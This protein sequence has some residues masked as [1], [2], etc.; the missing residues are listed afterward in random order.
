MRQRIKMLQLV[1]KMG[2][3]IM[4][5]FFRYS[6]MELR[7]KDLFHMSDYDTCLERATDILKKSIE[8]AL[9]FYA[10]A[11]ANHRAG[12]DHQEDRAEEIKV[13]EADEIL[14][15]REVKAATR[16]WWLG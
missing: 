14:N 8:R 9:K 6:I 2:F 16:G 7:I 10:L 13:L 3:M 4:Q 15:E 1:I 12:K 11:I 5:D